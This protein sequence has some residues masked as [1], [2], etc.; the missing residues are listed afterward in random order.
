MAGGLAS[1]GLK[2][3]KT[4]QDGLRLNGE[5]RF[6][7]VGVNLMWM[8]RQKF[9]MVLVKD[10]KAEFIQGELVKWCLTVGGRAWAQLQTGQGKV[11]IC[12]QG[13]DVGLSGWQVT[14]RNCGEWAGFGLNPHY[15]I[16]AEGWL[17]WSDLVWGY[18]GRGV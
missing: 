18:W 7:P 3:P 10:D 5:T 6:V 4:R 15:G 17:G 11:G 14:K 8:L 2:G 16:F 1:R 12:S 9:L 13:V